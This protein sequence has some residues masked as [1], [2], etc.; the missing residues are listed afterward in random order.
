MTNEKSQEIIF[1]EQ[2]INQLLKGRDNLNIKIETLQ[3]L[4]KKLTS[5]VTR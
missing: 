2:E 1:V 5:G 4:Y 3:E